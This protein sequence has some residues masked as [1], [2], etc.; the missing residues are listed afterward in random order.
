MSAPTKSDNPMALA[1]DLQTTLARLRMAR[2]V[3]DK[4][5]IKVSERRLDWLL[6]K[7]ARQQ[8]LTSLPCTTELL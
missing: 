5:E 8:Q 7:V 1:K 2:L 4:Q 3:N 6:D